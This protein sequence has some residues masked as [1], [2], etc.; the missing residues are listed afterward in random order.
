MEDWYP[1]RLAP[2]DG[3]PVILWIKDEEAPPTYPVT[4][5]VWETDD[6]T[7]WSHWRVF[8]AQIGTHIYFDRH[9][10]GWRPLPSVDRA[11]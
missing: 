7:G 4:V 6:I 2:R 11:W 5:G 9:V 1:K 8:G 10:V 3:T